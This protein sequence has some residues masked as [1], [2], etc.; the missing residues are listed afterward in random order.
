VGL[1]ECDV[2]CAAGA[3]AL[4][5]SKKDVAI[6]HRTAGLIFISTLKIQDVMPGGAIAPF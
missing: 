2:D 3:D 6:S 4:R 1:R 5:Q